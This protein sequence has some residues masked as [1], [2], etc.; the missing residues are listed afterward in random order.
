MPW[1]LR[2][3]IGLCGILLLNALP[4]QK[5]ESGIWQRLAGCQLIDAADN[6]ADRFKV[7]YANETLRIRL[8]FV[9][10]PES[11]HSDSDCVRD[12]AR[13]FS[14]PET[15]IIAAGKLAKQFSERFLRGGFT[16]I[17]QWQDGRHGQEPC[18]FA[19]VEK[20]GTLLSAALVQ[21]GAARLYGM[22]P[23]TTWPGGI[24][25]RAYLNVLK[26]YERS[27]QHSAA[28]IWAH[29]INAPQLAGLDRLGSLEHTAR[30]PQ[31]LALGGSKPPDPIILN[32]AD[33]AALQT[34]PGIGPALAARIIA[35]RPLSTVDALA[36]IPGISAN[37]IDAFRAR[38]LVDAPPPPPYTAACYLADRAR[39]LNREVTVHVA[40]V[41]NIKR[42]APPSFRAVRVYTAHNGAAGGAIDTFIP[43]EF[44]DSFIQYYRQPGRDLIALLFEYE[45]DVV[46]VYRR[47]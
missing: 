4:A 40:S 24:A 12:Q 41:A 47:K 1:H 27:A 9:D 8:Y 20:D 35:A 23:Q 45:A 6:E 28:G 5:R 25:P 10:S 32:S 26:Q 22:P 7:Q 14:L 30:A 19:L 13:Y 46:L 15:D 37:T 36:A 42:A 31:N 29:A 44:Y 21:H 11:D 18:Y 2:I 33:T 38:V 3:I 39:Y 43:E 16:V 17:T 34:L